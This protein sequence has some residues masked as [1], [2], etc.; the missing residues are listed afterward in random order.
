MEKSEHGVGGGNREIEKNNG[1]D[2]KDIGT[3]PN[4]GGTGEKKRNEI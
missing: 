3:P 2:R 1:G 4:G